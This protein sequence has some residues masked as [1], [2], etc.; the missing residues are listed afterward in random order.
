M[1]NKSETY[2]LPLLSE[3]VSFD[4]RFAKNIK[5]TYIN[6]DDKKYENCIGVIYEFSFKN[7]EFTHYENKLTTNELFVDLFDI[8]EDVLYIFKFP[9]EYMHEYECYKSGLYSKFGLDAKELIL[10]YYGDLY[11]GNLSATSFLLKINQVL[12]KDKKLKRQLEK[13]LGVQIDDNAELSS[14]PS[15][16]DETF[17]LS[18]IKKRNKILIDNNGDGNCLTDKNEEE[19]E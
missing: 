15:M 13:E 19:H 10:E 11:K 9:E 2:L 17:N 4:K 12:F 7:P 14:V 5:C 18:D 6:F 16:E 1:R 8:G 3:I